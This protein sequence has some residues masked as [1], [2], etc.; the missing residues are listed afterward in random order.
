MRGTPDR[1]CNSD[2]SPELRFIPAH[3][4]NTS[5]KWFR[6]GSSPRMRGTQRRTL[7]RR[8]NLRFIPA[9][10]G[11]TSASGT[12]PTPVHPRRGTPQQKQSPHGSSPR[13]RGTPQPIHK[14]ADSHTVHPR[15]CGE[16]LKRLTAGNNP[17]SPVHPRACG[18]H[19]EL[20]KHNWYVLAVHPRACGEHTKPRY[21]VFPVPGSSPRMR[22]TQRRTL[23]MRRYNLRFIPA[24]AGNTSKRTPRRFIPAHDTVVDRTCPVHPRACGEHFPEHRLR[25]GPH[26]RFIPAHAG[27]TFA[28]MPR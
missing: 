18:E 21:E 24:H 20:T 23:R 1:D 11:N 5:P 7:L 10:A 15:A 12:L 6:N 17:R 14:R 28:A 8:Y 22:G 27:N 3:A 19:T 26:M 13:M 25:L 4:G 16:H 2:R 9:H